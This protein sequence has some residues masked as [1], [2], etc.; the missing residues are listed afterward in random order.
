MKNIKKRLLQNPTYNKG[1]CKEFKLYLQNLN[2]NDYL[3]MYAIDKYFIR[4]NMF[5]CPKR[6]NY[7]INEINIFKKNATITNYDYKLL[8]DQYHDDDKTC[9]CLD[10]PYLYSDN[11]RLYHKDKI[12]I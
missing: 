4:G 10:P 3:K 7:N 9:L 12:Q 8:F 2:I 1:D 6:I 5:K 11:S